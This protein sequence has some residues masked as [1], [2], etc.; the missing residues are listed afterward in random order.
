MSRRTTRDA[1]EAARKERRSLTTSEREAADSKAQELT[2]KEMEGYAEDMACDAPKVTV[3][4]KV[5]VTNCPEDRDG[6]NI[7]RQT[8]IVDC[9]DG[10]LY[11]VFAYKIDG[12]TVIWEGIGGPSSRK[13]VRREP[14]GTLVLLDTIRQGDFWA[15]DEPILTGSA[16]IDSW[17]WATALGLLPSRQTGIAANDSL[18]K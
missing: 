17:S 12:Q 3:D 18:K 9:S 14:D 2:A 1:N 7:N 13:F 10:D 15:Q 16:A 6:F 5:C 11:H 8:L 4:R